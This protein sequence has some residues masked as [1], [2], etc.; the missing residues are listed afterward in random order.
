MFKIG[1]A[2]LFAVIAALVAI[3][4]GLVSGARIPTVFLRAFL[5]FL[6]SWGCV[7]LVLFVLECK[8]IAGFDKHVDF[9]EETE[10]TDAELASLAAEAEA[11]EKAT[12][13]DPA[14]ASDGK[15][16]FQ[17]LSTDGLK[18]MDTAGSN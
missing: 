9:P 10:P 6:V 17:P 12:P 15:S 16:D 14:A 7:W 1:M 13:E 5:A 11:E 2:L 4:A 3:I 8:G 18:H